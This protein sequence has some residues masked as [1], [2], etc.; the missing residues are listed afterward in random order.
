MQ[1]RRSW[2]EITVDI[3]EVTLKPSNKMKIMYAS[4]LNFGRFTKYFYDL[5]KKGFITEVAN[6]RG[7]IEYIITDKG[8][9]LLNVLKKAQELLFS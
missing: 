4:N 2:P 7:N 6:S 1:E 9:V 5:L 3:L 8:K